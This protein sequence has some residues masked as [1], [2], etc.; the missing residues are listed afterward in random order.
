MDC[1]NGE[2]LAMTTNPSFDPSLF[3]SGVSRRSG[4][5]GPATARRP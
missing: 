1:R 2:V 3:N 5:N 4:S